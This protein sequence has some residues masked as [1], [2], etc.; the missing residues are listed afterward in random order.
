MLHIKFRGNR[1]TGSG[2]AL[3]CLRCFFTVY[4]RSSHLGHVTSIMLINYSK[5]A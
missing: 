1:S 2:E 5:L 3:I 4:G